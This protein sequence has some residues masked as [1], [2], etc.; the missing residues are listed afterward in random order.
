MTTRTPHGSSTAQNSPL[1]LHVHSDQQPIRGHIIALASILLLCG[2]LAG[3]PAIAQIPPPN[4]PVHIQSATPEVRINKYVASFSQ[5]N[6]WR[7]EWPIYSQFIDFRNTTFEFTDWTAYVGGTYDRTYDSRELVSWN[8]GIYQFKESTYIDWVPLPALGTK[9]Y[10]WSYGN[11]WAGSSIDDQ[12][13]PPVFPKEHVDAVWSNPTPQWLIDHPEGGDATLFQ[14]D[15]SKTA[16]TF[17]E[18]FSG[19]YPASTTNRMWA[20]QFQGWDQTANAAVMDAAYLTNFAGVTIGGVSVD[21]NGI[22][23]FR[24][25]DYTTTNVTPLLPAAFSNYTYEISP[26]ELTSSIAFDGN[27]DGQIDLYGISDLTTS[28]APFVFWVNNDRDVWT[29]NDQDFI[30]V[31]LPAV[32]DYDQDWIHNARDL[33]DY[34]RLAIRIPAIVCRDTNWQCRI[35]YGGKIKLFTYPY[36]DNRHVQ[37]Q[38]FAQNTLVKNWSTTNYTFDTGWG[39]YVGE[40]ISASPL[41]LPRNLLETCAQFERPNGPYGPEYARFNFLFKGGSAGKHRIKLE[42]YLSLIHI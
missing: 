13:K 36:D 20:L 16:Q 3:D 19:G 21:A 11:V 34:S 4:P 7:L 8:S 38:E 35:S 31:N 6:H 32:K 29:N 14:D 18:F 42:L 22:A 12:V 26:A 41:N 30:D 15:N 37:E 17:V 33:E 9:T 25:K 24:M 2:G 5:T 40:S 10:K 27:N 28:A 1:P 23:Y 39:Y